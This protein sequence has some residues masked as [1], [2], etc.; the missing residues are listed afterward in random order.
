MRLHTEIIALSVGTLTQRDND[1]RRDTR[2]D[3][4]WVILRDRPT[5][6]ALTLSTQS[7]DSYFKS[8]PTV[9]ARLRSYSRRLSFIPSVTHRPSRLLSS[10]M[11][12]GNAT[13]DDR[14]HH[15]KGEQTIRFDAFRDELNRSEAGNAT[16]AQRSDDR[17]KSNAPETT[18]THLTYMV[19]DRILTNRHSS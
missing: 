12:S 4:S 18:R 14:S 17:P 3:R 11:A 9:G 6:W 8:P 15:T 7:I 16:K 5:N 2:S 19:D 13:A 1:E 10:E